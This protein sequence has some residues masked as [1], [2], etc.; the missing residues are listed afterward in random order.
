MAEWVATAATIATT[1][2]IAVGVM[3][4]TLGA[5]SGTA[6]TGAAK[7]VAGLAKAGGMALQGLTQ[8]AGGL[9]QAAKN[10][11][12]IGTSALRHEGDVAQADKKKIDAVITVL[13]KAME[14]DG[15]QLK[16]IMKEME[17]GLQVVTQMLAGAA[18]SRSQLAGNLVAGR[19]V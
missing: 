2:A 5:G 13:M 7:T 11:A 18:E 6:L 15:E 16:K 4:I 1:V 19:M 9:T 3:V 12:G 8:V 17:D 14:E 10:G